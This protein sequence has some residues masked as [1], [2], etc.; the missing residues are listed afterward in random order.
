M[1]YN[2][3]NDSCY[4]ENF[5]KL[6]FGSCISIKWLSDEVIITVIINIIIKIFELTQISYAINLIASLIVCVLELSMVNCISSMLFLK[7]P[8]KSVLK[9]F[10]C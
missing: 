1:G 8:V 7:K 2:K 6:S 4:L 10:V 9:S 5:V 3:L